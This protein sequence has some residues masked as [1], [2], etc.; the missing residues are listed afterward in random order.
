MICNVVDHRENTYDVRVD[1]VMESSC[2]DNSIGASQFECVEN[3][4][5]EERPDTTVAEIMEEAAK[6]DWEV[7]VFLYSLGGLD[8]MPVL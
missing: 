4:I 8:G 5:V 3:P 6:I 7:T 2:N 1:A